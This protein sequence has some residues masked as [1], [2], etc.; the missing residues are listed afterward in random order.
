MIES[1]KNGTTGVGLIE[2]YDVDVLSTSQVSNI[3]TRGRVQTGNNVMIGGFIV[4]GA[5]GSINL[6]VRVL[7]PTL[8]QFGVANAL[9]DPTLQLYDGNGTII[10][11]NNN[12]K[13]SQQTQI[14]NSGRQPPNNLE[15]AIAVTVSPGNYTAIVRGNN[16]TTG[17]GLVE[18]YQVSSF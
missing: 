9:A 15:P 7:G 12:W 10:A 17:V 8:T 13:D 3:S 4:S 6:V 1:G 5:S 14:Q 2:V 11:S 16:N 18:V